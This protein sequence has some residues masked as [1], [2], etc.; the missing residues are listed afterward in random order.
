MASLFAECGVLACIPEDEASPEEVLR[1]AARLAAR[2][3]VPLGVVHVS[4]VRG[5]AEPDSVRADA[6]ARRFGAA[7]WHLRSDAP[8]A[9]LRA[10]ARRC[11]AVHV[12]LGPAGRKTWGGEPYP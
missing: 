6:R 5:R 7:S 11:R 9:S 4:P 1:A 3:G 2:L 12:V 8:A 10:F